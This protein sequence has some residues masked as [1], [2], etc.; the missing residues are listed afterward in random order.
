MLASAAA[1]GASQASKS[2]STAASRIRRYACPGER[3]LRRG[4]GLDTATAE[5]TMLRNEV[6]RIARTQPRSSVNG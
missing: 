4:R 6:E 5:G 3:E 1:V 2:I